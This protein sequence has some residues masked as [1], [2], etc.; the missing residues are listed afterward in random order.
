MS[1]PG[2]RER[3]GEGERE[4]EGPSIVPLTS[5]SLSLSLPFPSDPKKGRNG[6][7][8]DQPWECTKV[9]GIEGEAVLCP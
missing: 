3:V 1:G 6:V 9:L 5:P 7:C 4:R 8:G 2:W